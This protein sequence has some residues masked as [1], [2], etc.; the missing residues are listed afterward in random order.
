[1]SKSNETV[2]IEIS[3]KTKQNIN[4]K[5]N[6]IFKITLS[7]CWECSNYKNKSPDGYTRIRFGDGQKYLHRI[8]YTMFKGRLNSEDVVMHW[9]DNPACN[10]PE[11]LNKGTYRENIDDMVRKGRQLTG[12]KNGFAK[13]N[14]HQVS[15]IKY[16]LNM[17]KS[18]LEIGKI[19]N[20]SRTTIYDIKIGKTWKTVR[21]LE[22]D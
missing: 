7:G 21:K 22:L 1:L 14:E 19:F 20:V 11:H 3:Y 8:I 18:D 10:N 16:L 15:E 5:K 12:S 2:N 9:C 6:L 4:R 17:G 13:L